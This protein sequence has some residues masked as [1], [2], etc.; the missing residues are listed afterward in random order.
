MLSTRV[1]LYYL[2]QARDCTTKNENKDNLWN[3]T[4]QNSLKTSEEKEKRGE[5]EW[6]SKGRMFRQIHSFPADT[7]TLNINTNQHNI[8]SE[9]NKRE[10]NIYQDKE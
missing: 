6:I 5:N 1:H 3:N 9:M 8:L 7:I 4:V 10:T 2:L